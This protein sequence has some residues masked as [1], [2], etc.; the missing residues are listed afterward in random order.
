MPCHPRQRRWVSRWRSSG[1]L[2]GTSAA[3]V[4]FSP[5]AQYDENRVG[6][7]GQG[8]VAIPALPVAHLVMIEPAL[9]LGGLEGLLDLPALASHAHQRS[10]VRFRRGCMK[11]IVSMFWLLFD[12]AP[13]Q[14]SVTPAILLP[15]MNE[16]PVIKPFAFTA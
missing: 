3:G 13:H 12:A 8:D 4:F 16:R 10:Q 6:Q 15:A 14:Q 11:P 7:H 5:C 2:S 1:T 9:A